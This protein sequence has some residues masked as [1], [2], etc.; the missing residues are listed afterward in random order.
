MHNILTGG[1]VVRQNNL[2]TSHS[3]FI[4]VAYDF[5]LSVPCLHPSDHIF[6]L[7]RNLIRLNMKLRLKFCNQLIEFAYLCDSLVGIRKL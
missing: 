3:Y 7:L 4:F 6:I 2:R 1:F 5:I